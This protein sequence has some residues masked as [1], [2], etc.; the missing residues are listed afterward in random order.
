MHPILS[1]RRTLILYLAVWFSIALLIEIPFIFQ[2]KNQWAVFLLS[3]VPLN[4]FFSFICLSSYYL[5]K[6]FP[7]KTTQWYNLLSLFVVAACIAAGFELL[8]GYGW[9][10]LIDAL[11]IASPISSLYEPWIAGIFSTLVLIFLLIA[12]MHYV[13]IG[14]ERSSDSERQTFELR[15]L[16]QDA[17][18][19]ALRAQIDPH[20]LFNSLN[21]ISA[22]TTSDPNKARTMTLMLADFFRKSLELGSRSH[23]PLRDEL[24]LI[25]EFLTI[26]HVR[27]GTRLKV[28]QDIKEECQ[29]I[30]VPPLILQPLVENAV[31]HGIAHLVEG[32]TIHLQCESHGDRIIIQIQN[33]ID[34]DRPRRK[35]S[36]LGLKNVRSRLNTLYD[37][38]ARVDVEE[39]NE[40]FLI[41][42]TFP[43]RPK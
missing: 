9:V 32:G 39:T 1:N 34:P 33:P 3:D 12:S 40:Y 30:M 11:K 13:I 17:E 18:L 27:F 5:C 6:V 8:I 24:A 35:G 37:N 41:K 38:E 21:S 42:L 22:L 4:L 25:S 10:Q 2:Y 29:K 31:R 43:I 26:E 16:A 20:F 14:F 23:I 36:G 15:L 19:R 7:V 28:V